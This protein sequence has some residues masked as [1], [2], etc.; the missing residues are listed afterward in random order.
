[1][2]NIPKEIADRIDQLEE[3]YRNSGQDL[4]SYL[5][6]LLHQRFLTYWDYIHLDTLLS[7]QIPRTIF[8]MRK[9][10]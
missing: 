7:L 6:G 1:M 5:D 10:L 2:S 9:C 3:K 4:G 8:L